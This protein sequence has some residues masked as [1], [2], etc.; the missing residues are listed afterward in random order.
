MS[1]S[2]NLISWGFNKSN[3]KYVKKLDNNYYIEAFLN[4]QGVIFH[5]CNNEGIKIVTIQTVDFED[6]KAAYNQ[7]MS[8]L[9]EIVN[10]LSVK[11]NNSTTRPL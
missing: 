10:M 8:F 5:L 4:G 6:I 3:E 2:N 11:N 7:L 1:I 9:Q